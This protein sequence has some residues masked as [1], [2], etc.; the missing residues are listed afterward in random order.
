MIMDFSFNIKLTDGMILTS[1][2]CNQGIIHI[3]RRSQFE[4]KNVYYFIFNGRDKIIAKYSYLGI[5][6]ISGN[7]MTRFFYDDIDDTVQISRYAYK[8]SSKRAIV[9]NFMYTLENQWKMWN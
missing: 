3:P 5:E 2:E 6:K 7:R 4:Y 8:E 1:V 9:R